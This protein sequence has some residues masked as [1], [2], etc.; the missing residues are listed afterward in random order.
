MSWKFYP[1]GDHGHGHDHSTAQGHGL[2][3]HG[4]WSG[5]THPEGLFPF[6]V[7]SDPVAYN[8][9]NGYDVASYQRL[10]VDGYTPYDVVPKWYQVGKYRLPLA[11]VYGQNNPGVLRRDFVGDLSSHPNVYM[12]IW[13]AP[14]NG[15]SYNKTGGMVNIPMSSYTA[16]QTQVNAFSANADQNSMLAQFIASKSPTYTG[17]LSQS[18]GE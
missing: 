17:T 5:H 12:P 8:E 2:G 9:D 16:G 14:S 10:G 4:H 1:S 3:S 13:N 7:G 15:Q 11:S 6:S 18:G